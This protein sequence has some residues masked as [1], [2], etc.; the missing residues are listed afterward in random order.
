MDPREDASK[1]AKSGACSAESRAQTYALLY[2]GDGLAALAEATSRL[3]NGDAITNM[4]AI[5]NLAM[6]VRNGF[7]NLADA[8]SQTG[9]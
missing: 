4:G 3:G 6:M 1:Y 9:S 7:A 8:I 2:I 5:E